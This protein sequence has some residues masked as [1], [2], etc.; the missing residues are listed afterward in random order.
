MGQRLALQKVGGKA[1][2]RQRD[3]VIWLGAG[4]ADIAL[5]MA[6]A[7]VEQFEVVDIDHQERQL[8]VILPGLHPLEVEPALEA[9]PVGE[10]G[11]LT[12]RLARRISQL[13][14]TPPAE[15]RI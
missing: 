2:A 13:R 10:A 1:S 11:R 4:K 6:I 7:I 5:G 12:G 15:A 8:A 9:A 14:P 3:P